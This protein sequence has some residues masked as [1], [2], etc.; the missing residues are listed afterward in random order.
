MAGILR[1]YSKL[2]CTSLAVLTLAACSPSPES[3]APDASTAPDAGEDVFVSP[4]ASPT[5]AEAV[6]IPKLL[7]GRWG[8]VKADCTST[9]GDA[10]GLV[11]ID[12]TS[13]KFYEALAR[14]TVVKSFSANAME[15]EFS[16]SGEGQ[17]W[18]LDVALSTADGGKTLVRKDS[19]PDALPGTQTYMKCT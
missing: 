5:T 1:N 14:L 8:L 12:P 6:G 4:T 15:G 2:A 11:T 19:G 17:S 10:K 9:A 13:L 18:T 16:F 3:P 7:Q